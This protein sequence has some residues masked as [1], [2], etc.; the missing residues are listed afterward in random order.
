MRPLSNTLRG[1]VPCLLVILALAVPS[2]ALA[3]TTTPYVTGF[4]V[5]SSD[6]VG[7]VGLTFDP[8]GT[9]YAT[10][11]VDGNVYRFGPGG[12]TADAAHVFGNVGQGASGA[13]WD[14]GHLYVANQFSGAIYELDTLTGAILR[15]VFPAGI[16]CTTGLA[17]DPTTGDLYST[18]LSCGPVRRIQDPAGAAIASVYADP[19]DDLDGIVVAPDG[20]IYAAGRDQVVERIEGSQSSN[21]GAVSVVAQMPYIDGIALTARPGQP[22]IV[23]GNGIDGV[24]R[25]VDLASA[26]T[27]T[28]VASPGERGDLATVGPDGCLYATQSDSILRVTHADGRCD[29]T[30]TGGNSSGKVTAGVLKTAGG[31][32]GFNVQSDGR[33]IKGELEYHAGAQN[34]HSAAFSSLTVTP[35]GTKAWFAGTLVDGRAFNAYVEDNGEPGRSDVFRLWV[36]G[37]EVTGGATSLAGGNVQIHR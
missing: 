35:D 23:Y 24:I 29:L 32:G 13:V 25:S 17:A 1:F 18:S 10:D 14:R 20:T 21:P 15:T 31:R 5:A 4:Q 2:A 36:A 33:S 3:D 26:T 27:G 22:P 8:S 37:A 28:V 34:L 16:T 7:P 12:G 19:Q 11:Y 30:Y 6:P 9:L